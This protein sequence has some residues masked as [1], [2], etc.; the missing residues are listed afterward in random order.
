[1]QDND[2]K[3]VMHSKRD[4]IKIMVNDKG[5]DEVIKALSDLLINIYQNNLESMKG[6]EFV[7]IYVHLLY[8]K[9]H[10]LNPN[11]GGS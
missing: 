9:Y 7:F 11:R 6:D 1:M 5:E 2:E 8:Y 3:R 4:K 10:K